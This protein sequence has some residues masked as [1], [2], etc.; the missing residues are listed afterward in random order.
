MA[1][2]PAATR[3]P[4][5]PLAGRHA[6]QSGRRPRYFDGCPVATAMSQACTAA[7]RAR[8]L[9][10]R[11]RASCSTA[12]GRGPPLGPQ[13]HATT[14]RPLRA[15]PPPRP[16]AVRHPASRRARTGPRQGP[17]PRRGTRRS[18]A[19]H[20]PR[21]AAPGWHSTR[22]RGWA[23]PSRPTLKSTLTEPRPRDHG[24]RRMGEKT[25][26]AGRP[27]GVERGDRRTGALTGAPL[28]NPTDIADDGRVVGGPARPGR[29]AVERGR[30]RDPCGPAAGRDLGRHD[31]AGRAR[32][33]AGDSVPPVHQLAR[34]TPAR[35]RAYRPCRQS[36]GD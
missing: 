25:A 24:V 7:S 4:S 33:P 10:P 18:R 5:R 32:P 9:V 15:P 21:A 14:P 19:G 8:A 11:P 16:P 31:P 28:A 27:R 26:T 29:G 23:G 6:A 12:A 3:P 13:A 30:H 2:A 1:C 34:R 22:C 17:R 20:P 36:P 35:H